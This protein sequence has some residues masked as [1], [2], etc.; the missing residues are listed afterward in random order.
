MITSSTFRFSLCMIACIFFLHVERSRGTYIPTNIDL[1]VR[2][3]DVAVA[4]SLAAL[5]TVHSQLS[6]DLPALITAETKND[7]NWIVEHSLASA[8]LK[9]GF[10]VM[11][12]ST[13]APS[14]APRFTFRVADY[15][16]TG[17]SGLRGG[18]VKRRCHLTLVLR[19]IIGGELVWQNEADS[20]IH[21]KIP[22][23]RLEVLQN[24]TYNFADLELEERSWGRFIEPAVVSSVLGTLVYLFFSSR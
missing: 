13:A 18:E 4:K 22:K 14:A 9:Q 21:D 12:D 17:W 20:V 1:T 6:S 11:T 24:V 16:I 10:E 2:A 7:A 5:D 3:A 23:N 15:S 19:L 8:L